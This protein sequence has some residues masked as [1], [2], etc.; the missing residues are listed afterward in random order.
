MV[1]LYVYLCCGTP[2]VLYRQT[3][4]QEH[5]D[6]WVALAVLDETEGSCSRESDEPHD[7]DMDEESLNPR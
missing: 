3:W 1:D 6:E 2:T 5:D 7:E 4:S